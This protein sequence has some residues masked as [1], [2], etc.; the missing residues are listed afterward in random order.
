[1]RGEG[2]NISTLAHLDEAVSHYYLIEDVCNYVEGTHGHTAP[3]YTTQEAMLD[4]YQD[5]VMENYYA[6]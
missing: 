5:N 2:R 1:M 6:G 4:D 3:E